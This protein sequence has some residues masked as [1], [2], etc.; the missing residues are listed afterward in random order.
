MAHQ[1]LVKQERVFYKETLDDT[2]IAVEESGAETPLSNHITLDFAQQIHYPF[3]PL[4]PAPILFKTPRKCGI[5][6]VN[7]APQPAN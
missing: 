1:A 2:T 5:F 7:S 3:D 6:G 4:Q